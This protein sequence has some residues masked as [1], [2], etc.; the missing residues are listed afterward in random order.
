MSDISQ[1]L[2]QF[3]ARLGSLP[4]ES[5]LAEL[6]EQN[7]QLRPELD[8]RL[9]AHLDQWNRNPLSS[10]EFDALASEFENE[11]KKGNSPQ[12]ESC[13]DRAPKASRVELLELLLQVEAYQRS[14]RN[15]SVDWEAYKAQ[16]PNYLSTIEKAQKLADS[17][18]AKIHPE[19]ST[20]RRRDEASPHR[21]GL[22]DGK[23]T[24]WRDLYH[25]RV[26]RRCN[27]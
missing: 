16:F 13:L 4:A 6:L 12:I 24:L 22:F 17:S 5:I 19:R 26:H 7:P 9:Q 21:H 14:K 10:D 23:N 8:G 25:L 2:A 1:I 3:Q 15:E 18:L 20:V 27:T 11:F